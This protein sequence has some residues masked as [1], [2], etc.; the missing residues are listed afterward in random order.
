LRLITNENGSMALNMVSCAE[1]GQYASCCVLCDRL[2]AL[3]DC[4]Q[5]GFC[6]AHVRCGVR[7]LPARSYPERCRRSS[8]GLMQ[9]FRRTCILFVGPAAFA[10]VAH[11][12]ASWALGVG[13]LS[14]L[15]ALVTE[16]A[17][18]ARPMLPARD[19][20]IISRMSEVIGD[21][22]LGAQA[23][24][25]VAHSLAP[26]RGGVI[27]SGLHREGLGRSQGRRR[28]TSRR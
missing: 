1:I 2:R 6:S 5:G 24:M 18:S 28:I 20:R 22:V 8:G 7:N 19:V 26:P 13:S 9:A 10:P 4:G 25:G 3:A 21:D 15:A 12:E 27:V 11:C 14:A 16:A 17:P 23:P